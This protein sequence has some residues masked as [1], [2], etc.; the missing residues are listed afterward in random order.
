[1]PK[2]FPLTLFFIATIVLVAVYYQSSRPSLHVFHGRTMGTTY[3]IKYVAEGAAP[4]KEDVGQQVHRAL[5]DVDDRMSTYQPDSELMRF[6]RS[7]LN[8]AFFA[9]ADLVALVAESQEVSRISAGAYDVTI[10]PLVNLWG[11][12]AGN[13]ATVAS[14]DSELNDPAFVQWLSANGA[15]RVP[16][17][18]NVQEAMKTVGFSSVVVDQEKQTLTRMKPVFI[19]LSS[20]AKGYGVDQ[21]AQA[22]EVLGITHYMVEVGGEVRIRGRKPDGQGW[23]IAIRPPELLTSQTGEIIEAEN[24]GIATSGDYLN[25]YEW[26][27][28]HYSHLIDA[29]T[30]YPEKHRLTSVAVVDDSTAKADAYATMFMILGEEKGLAVAE[31]EGLA[32]YF[33]YHT[34]QGFESVASSTFE[35]YRVQ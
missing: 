10:G 13:Q 11:F 7:P 23:R 28:V 16:S 25:Y 27:G 12:G 17:A 4:S 15:S 35:S 33:I 31:K 6:N 32:A 26:E 19:D 8:E 18:D 21:A 5:Q 1:M 34:S 22:L 29:R 30:G 20:I 3:N 14:L 2:R 24:K 9:S